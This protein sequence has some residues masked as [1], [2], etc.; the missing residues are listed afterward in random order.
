ME[1]M[2][3]E[4][5]DVYITGDDSGL[6]IDS[7]TADKEDSDSEKPTS[8]LGKVEIS[9]EPTMYVTQ[10]PKGY[11]SSQDQR[12]QVPSKKVGLNS[13][14]YL[15]Q[16]E[17]DADGSSVVTIHVPVSDLATQTSDSDS[18]NK[19][20]TVNIQ[21]DSPTGESDG[22][23]KFD[24]E[25]LV[26]S[27][28]GDKYY[29]GK[30][31]LP[32]KIRPYKLPIWKRETPKPPGSISNY[33]YPHGLRQGV[34]SRLIID[35]P[36]NIPVAEFKAQMADTSDIVTTL[37]VAPSTKKR[38]RELTTNSVSKLFAYPGKT[39]PSKKLYALYQRHLTSQPQSHTNPDDLDLQPLGF[40]TTIDY[41][42]V[43][44]ISRKRSKLELD[45]PKKTKSPDENVVQDKNPRENIVQAIT[46]VSNQMVRVLLK[47]G[48]LGEEQQEILVLHDGEDKGSEVNS[49]TLQHS[50]EVLLAAAESGEICSETGGDKVYICN[51]DKGA[52]NIEQVFICEDGTLVDDDG[53]F[54]TEQIIIL[55]DEDTQ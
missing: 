34:R 54:V 8:V 29:I 52:E 44:R 11:K 10:L 26:I 23:V 39:F 50:I 12:L 18:E 46:P 17:T 42:Q 45:S 16:L 4:N 24:P 6:C 36:T 43:K 41:S 25:E 51:S 15:R 30:S 38:I 14:S 13:P 27:S 32:P 28:I 5:I 33:L 20:F 55:Q 9:S 22:I 35:C 1:F 7:D 2:N 3:E 21:I 31:N 48:V 37:D 19:V 53:E 40:S 47:P 49:S